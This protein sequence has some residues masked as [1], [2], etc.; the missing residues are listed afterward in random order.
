MRAISKSE[1]IFPKKKR[2]CHWSAKTSKERLKSGGA[3]CIIP[4]TTLRKLAI[5]KIK[6]GKNSICAK[7]QRNQSEILDLVAKPV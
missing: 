3:S 6:S 1:P 2:I 5:F 7:F 4:Y